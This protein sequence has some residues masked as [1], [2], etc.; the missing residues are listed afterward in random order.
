[1]VVTESPGFSMDGDMLTFRPGRSLPRYDA[2]LYLDEAHA[3]GVFGPQGLGLAEAE[4]MLE[5]VDFLVGTFWQGPGLPRG[6]CGLWPGRGRNCCAVP[7]VRSS[8]TTGAAA[9]EPGLDG[10]DS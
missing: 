7:C 9:I 5:E 10:L 1:M 8:F 3:L 2:A 6:L 4:G